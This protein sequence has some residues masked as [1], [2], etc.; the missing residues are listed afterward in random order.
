MDN[1]GADNKHKLN[2]WIK[3]LEGSASQSFH[4]S[5]L[6]LMNNISHIRQKKKQVQEQLRLEE[7]TLT[8]AE[9]N[10]NKLKWAIQQKKEKIEGL[11]RHKT[12]CGRKQMA[13][14][15]WLNHRCVWATLKRS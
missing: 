9:R 15:V 3:P 5:Q 13:A 14:I 2:K 6:K 10:A 12:L 8:N 4:M 11:G 7:T 1:T